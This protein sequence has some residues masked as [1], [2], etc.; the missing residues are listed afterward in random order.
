MLHLAFWGAEL[1]V[2]ENSAAFKVSILFISVDDFPTGGGGGANVI[3]GNIIF[4]S[5]H[6]K[7]IFCDFIWRSNSIY[8]T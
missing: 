6:T 5:K 7:E 3:R 4:T 8:G 2:L 1:Q